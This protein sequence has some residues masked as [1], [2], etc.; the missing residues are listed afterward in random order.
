MIYW[1]VDEQNKLA[2]ES[3]PTFLHTNETCE[4]LEI[5]NLKRRS[6]WLHGR[7]TAKNLLQKY[8]PDCS[9]SP[10]SEILIKK[11][12]TGAPFAAHPIGRELSGSLSISH[13]DALAASALVLE[14]QARI[15][16]DLERIE[17]RMVEYFEAYL[18]SQ[19][20]DTLETCRIG[21]QP[22]FLTLIWSAK[23]SVLKAIG[24]RFQEPKDIEINVLLEEAKTDWA[25]YEI[26]VSLDK[27]NPLIEFNWQGWWKVYK[28]YIL[29]IALARQTDLSGES[30]G[31]V[32]LVQY[33]D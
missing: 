10:L 21:D 31:H 28:K 18:T 8:H 17:S 11:S 6:Q 13:K 2:G 7:W 19:E 23:E 12:E 24:S 22:L 27:K 25:H 14:S 33:P 4:F 3:P 1:M 29:T 32:T 16:I 30:L 5:K 9:S 20:L 26:L 15:G